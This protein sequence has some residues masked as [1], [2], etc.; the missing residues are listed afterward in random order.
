MN[1]L[2]HLYL[3]DPDP[4]CRLGNMM[5]DFV[6][7][8]LEQHALPPRIL[9]GLRQHRAVD[10][11]AVSHPAVRRSR[12]RLDSRFGHTR[13]ILVDI[14]YDH[15]LAQNWHQWTRGSLPDF[16][17]EIY[18]LLQRNEN[19]LP[20]AF[21]MVARRMIEHDWLSAYRKPETIRLV[22]AR[23]A[24]RLTRPNLLAQGYTELA[25]C[26]K[27]MQTDCRTFLHAARNMLDRLVN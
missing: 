12:T 8:R 10:R 22:L 21:R 13:G 23:M 14:F 5:G 9:K 1:Y 16:T 26:G 17:N 19:L 15:L 7:G 18:R 24:P 20:N 6:K 25:R 4:L 3:S 2:A 27:E 11:L